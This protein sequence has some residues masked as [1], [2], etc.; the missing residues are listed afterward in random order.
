VTD[1]GKRNLLGVL[2]DALDYEA[3]VTRII[4]AACDRRA[5]AATALAVH[6]VMTGASDRTHRH[7]LNSLDL[8]TPDGQPVR[9]ALNWIHGARLRDRVYGPALMLRVCEEA[10][11][12]GLS[13]YLYGSRPAVV[14]ALTRALRKKLPALR[15]AGSEPSVFRVLQEEEKDALVGRIRRSGASI[16]FVG[17][18]CPRQEVFVY[19]FRSV[20][21]MPVIGVGA[22]FDYHSGFQREPQ[23]WVQRAGF[24][25][26]HRMLHEPRRLWKRYLISNTAFLARLGLQL[27][28]LIHPDPADT[29]PPQREMSLG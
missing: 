17:L 27:A 29:T 7:R 26:A 21:S 1:L 23:A 2:V 9:W 11:R 6:G 18:G 22:A 16:T 15:I 14:D 8:V 19:E 12:R 28:G 13:I 25:W 20:L 3:A 4:R 24:Q 10:A 5:Y